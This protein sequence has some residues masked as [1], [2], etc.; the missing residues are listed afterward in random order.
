MK[1]ILIV[2]DE[3]GILEEVK[4]FLEEEGFSVQSADTVKE[5]IVQLISFAPDL[6]IIDGKLPDG[7]GVDVLRSIR[8][9]SLETKVIISTGYVDQSF[10]DE[11]NALK[12]NLFLQKPYDLVRLLDEVRRVF[13]M[14]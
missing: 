11:T 5:G 8:D 3:V 9:Q 1:K 2:D 7:S 6:V 14:E 4:S 12:V 10:I 13:A